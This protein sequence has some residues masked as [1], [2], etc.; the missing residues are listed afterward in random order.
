[1][2]AAARGAI[3]Q[4]GRSRRFPVHG[5]RVP[6]RLA[7]SVSSFAAIACLVASSLGC[8][9]ERRAPA[10]QPCV[11]AAEG[12]WAERRAP[13]AGASD[14]TPAS[15]SLALTPPADSGNRLPPGAMISMVIAGP[16][17]AAVPD[18]VRLLVAEAPDGGPLWEGNAVRPGTYTASLT[19]EGFAAAPR[20]FAVAA[21]ERV[22]LQ[23]TLGRTC[24]SGSSDSA[25][26]GQA[27][28]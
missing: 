6:R 21:G 18:T 17:A 23:A 15:L 4:G 26:A 22:Q 9:T 14:T 1:M 12:A 19:T 7:G 11:P 25:R 24:E 20:E 8:R 28:P 27:R 2:H 5:A 16:A 3:M 13:V 10:D